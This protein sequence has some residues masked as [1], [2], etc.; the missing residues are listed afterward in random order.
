MVV[1]TGGT[2]DAPPSATAMATRQCRHVAT[3]VRLAAALDRRRLPAQLWLVTQG[4]QRVQPDDRV[5]GWVDGT[6]WGLGRAIG[7]ELP[8]LWAGCI[9]LDPAVP[10]LQAATALTGELTHLGADGE[11]EGEV[12]LRDARRFVGRL[13]PAEVP[14]PAP[15]ALPVDGTVLV[16]GGFGA[17][18]GEVAR[19]LVDQGARRVVLLGRTVLPPRAEW[20]GLDPDSPAGRRVATVRELEALGAAVHV[21]AVDA[22]D[23]AALIAFLDTFRTEGWPPIRVVVHAAAQFGGDLVG[24]VSVAAVRAQLLPK[25]VGAWTFHHHMADLQHLVLF[26]SIA[27][28]LPMAGQSAYAAANAFLDSLAQHRAAAGRPAVSIAWGFWEGSDEAVPGETGRG[29]VDGGRTYKDIANTLAVDQGIHGFGVDEGLATLHRLLP[30]SEPCTVVAAIDW[31]RLGAARLASIAGLAADRVAA[32]PPATG[33]PRSSSLVADIADAAPSEQLDVAEAAVR[34]IVGRVLKLPQG[35]IDGATP[36][37]SL[38]MDSLMSV[39]L[40]NLL[41]RELGSKLSATVAWNYPTVQEL[42]A[43]LVTR[44]VGTEAVPAEAAAPVGADP[45]LDALATKVDQLSEDEALAALMG[46]ERR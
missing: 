26:S 5:P 6:L 12:A 37:G 2:D 3:I 35:G 40:R 38:G 4:A 23:E 45:R 7:E 41:E 24:D 8:H 20:A 25:L 1:V 39:E 42:A 21:A 33:A 15:L 31:A 43:Y 46:G 14:A 34:R 44:V 32:A 29:H 22:G 27:G 17:V 16:T 11:V 10:P 30:G 28:S 19:W 13:G 36:F 18:G 9:D